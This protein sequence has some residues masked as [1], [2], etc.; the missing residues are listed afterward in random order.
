M[1]PRTVTVQGAL[2]LAGTLWAA[3]CSSPPTTQS[4]A[5]DAAAA[6]GGLDRLRGVQT[7]AMKG[8]TG[9]RLRLGQMVQATDE[10]MP[11]ALANVV[12]TLDLANGRAALDYEVKMGDFGQHRQEV[13]TKKNGK[14]VGLENVAGRPLAV[15]SPSGL[16]S[17]GTQNSPEFL[18]KRNVIGIV[19]AAADTA[20][21]EMPQTRDFGGSPHMFGTTRLASGETIGLYFNPQTKLLDGF[22]T[23]DTESM[24][25]DQPSVY[26]LADYR[27][28]AGVK[29]PHKITI[30]KGGTPYSEVQ[31][32]SASVNDAGAVAVFAIPDAA[33]AE[34]D[35]AIAAGDYSPVSIAKISDGV[36]LARAYSHNSLVVEFPS[37][38]AVVE[39]AYT[40]A[41]SAT[42]AR[43]LGEQF[44]R[45]PIRYA[46]VTHY[47]YDHSGGVR[48]LA[49][50][51]ATILAAKAH[52]A[53]MRPVMETPHTNPP[54]A[55]ELAKK[56]GTAG[57][58][59]FFEGTKVISDGGQSLELHAVTGIPHVEP[60]VLAFVPRGG[61]LFQSDLF[62]PGTGAP[63]GPDAVA[64]LQAVKALKLKVTTN[65][66]GH[67]GVGPFAELEKAVA[68]AQKSS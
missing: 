9:T 42:L 21:T 32:T 10:E 12:E 53:M 19:M 37:Y 47:H 39:A 35:K 68:A 3:G 17:W 49:A 16:F 59:E 51:G 28:V 41:Q 57:T 31:Y 62:F 26:T 48:G 36:Y 58:I 44:P 50:V 23:T 2:I 45:K 40:D 52:E 67:G 8:G 38:L 13:L 7:V 56:A 64:L 61:V 6:M 1:R 27:D 18:L 43:V 5:K 46:V 24:L 14:A 30:T 63:A 20:S 4:L 25:G 33:N 22:E 55:L 11:A 34:V 65:A 29:L 15:M 60:K 66:G 54:D